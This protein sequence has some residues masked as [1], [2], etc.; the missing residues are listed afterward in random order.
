MRNLLMTFF[1]YFTLFSFPCPLVRTKFP[2][3]VIHTPSAEPGSAEVG[4]E[5]VGFAEVEVYL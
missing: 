1:L 3:R 5:E 2:S 4:S